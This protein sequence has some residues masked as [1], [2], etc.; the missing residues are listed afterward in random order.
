M[1]LRRDMSVWLYDY[2]LLPVELTYTSFKHIYIYL[3]STRVEVLPD[4]NGKGK[5]LTV[6][7]K[8]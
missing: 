3:H 2:F 5:E 8:G 7:N 4:K 1:N 6:I